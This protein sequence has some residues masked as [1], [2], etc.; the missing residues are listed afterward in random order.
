ARDLPRLW[1]AET[2]TPRDRKE[3]L[4]T[5]VSE[6]VVTVQGAAASGGGGDHLGGWRPD[7]AADP[8]DPARRH[9]TSEDTVTLIRRLAAHTADQQIAAILNKQ[10]RCT[11]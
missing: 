9:R 3:L 2:T 1:T 8:L 5:L 6:A 4:R 11:G 10:G 7:R